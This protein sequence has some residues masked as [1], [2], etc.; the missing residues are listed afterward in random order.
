MPT[1]NNYSDYDP[2]AWIYERHWS[3]EVPPQLLNAIEELLIPRLP[4]GARILDLCCGTGF[5]A[6]QLAQRGFEITGL[7]AST[8]M[9]RFA[10]RNAPHSRFIQADARSFDL[11][12]SFEAVISTFDSLNHIMTLRELIGVFSHVFRSLVPGGLFLFD[13]N[14]EEGFLQHWSDYFAIVEDRQVCVLRG[15]Y[16]REQRVGRYDIT[17]FR[18][19]G[20]LWRRTDTMVSERCYTKKEILRA[21]KEVGFQNISTHDAEKELGL[22][23]HTGRIFFLARKDAQGQG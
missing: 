8:E 14:M 12:P 20:K 22:A 16:D 7:D 17:M 18:R 10:R 19:E 5:T 1:E 11:P 3:R 23:G 9:L 21:L 13:M 6:A 2:F 4:Q 15:T